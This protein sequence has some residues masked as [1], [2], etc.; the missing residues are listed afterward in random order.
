MSLDLASVHDC[1]IDNKLSLNSVKS[2]FL[3]TPPKL[4]MQQPFI[5]LNLNNISLSFHNSVKYLGL[6][7]DKQLNFTSNIE[8]IEQSTYP[9]IRL[10]TKL[11]SFLLKP[12][13]L[14]LY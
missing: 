9:V 13:L 2:F 14:K 6:Y 7:I 1:C 12:A 4:N 11:K 5:R 10:F 3:I 8:Y